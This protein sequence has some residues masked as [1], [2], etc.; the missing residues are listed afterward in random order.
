MS[1]GFVASFV[2]LSKDHINDA[3]DVPRIAGAF[4]E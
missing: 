2:M 3:A 4:G 1:F